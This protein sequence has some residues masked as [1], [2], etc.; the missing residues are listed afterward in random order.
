MKKTLLL[1]LSISTLAA[2][3]NVGLN[4]GLMRD[5]N[6]RVSGSQVEEY[7]FEA[8]A[9]SRA[10]PIK[11]VFAST[12]Q[13]DR[14]APLASERMLIRALKKQTFSAGGNGLVVEACSRQ[15]RTGCYTFIEC[16]G[17]AYDVPEEQVVNSL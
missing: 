10:M 4:S 8:I 7:S 15:L 14:N 3:S 6:S 17:T 16:R 2:C 9:R 5:L 1:F 12:C 11:P 13:K